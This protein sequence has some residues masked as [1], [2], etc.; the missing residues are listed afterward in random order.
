MKYTKAI[1][2]TVIKDRV[3]VAGVLRSLGLK[4]AGGAHTHISRRIR[5]F[6]ID[7][8]HF[9]GQRANYGPNH[10]GPRKT[11]WQ[12][13][14]ALRERGRRQKAYILRRALIESGREYRCEVE[15]CLNCRGALSFPELIERERKAL[16]R[17]RYKPSSYHRMRFARV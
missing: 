16:W 13:V 15:G 14:L 17:N 10:K 2:E 4:E 8:S 11:H 1:L 7:T 6:G 3:S 5:E 9:L 12:E